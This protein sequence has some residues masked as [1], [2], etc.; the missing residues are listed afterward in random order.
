MKPKRKKRKTIS[1]LAEETILIYTW[2]DKHTSLE[3]RVDRRMVDSDVPPDKDEAIKAGMEVEDYAHANWEKIITGGL[4]HVSW[5]M[6][7]NW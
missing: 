6:K 2:K 7:G 3:V 1:R 4:G 5:G